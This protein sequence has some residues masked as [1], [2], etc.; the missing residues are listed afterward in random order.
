MTRRRVR[1]LHEA[2]LITPVNIDEGSDEQYQFLAGEVLAA[3]LQY[4]TRRRQTA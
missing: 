3:H 2:E 1:T 4:P